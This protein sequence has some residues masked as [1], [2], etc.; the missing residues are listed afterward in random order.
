MIQNILFFLH[1]YPGCGGIETVTTKLAN[2]LV[3]KGKKICIYSLERN[4]SEE[5]LSEL[6]DRVM[7]VASKNTSSESDDNCEQLVHLMDEKKIEL[8]IFQDSY[9]P[10]ENLLLKAKKQHD[11]KIWVVE[12]NTPDS[13]ILA[14]TNSKPTKAFY[15]LKRALFYPLYIK[16]ISSQTRNRTRNL[17]NSFDKYILL[18][19]NFIPVW[20]EVTG[21]KSH[22]RLTYINN[23]LTITRPDSFQF[24]KEKICLFCGRLVSQKGLDMLMRIWEKV[25]GRSKDWNLIIV[26]DG[27]EKGK[28]EQ[29]IEERKLKNVYLEGFRKNT[30][31]YYFKSSILCMASIYEGWLLSLVEAMAYGCVPFTFNSYAAAEDIIQNGENGY[32][33]APFAEDEYVEKLVGLMKSGDELKVMSRNAFESSSKFSVEKIGQK[34]LEII[35]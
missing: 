10:V 2:F 29:F 15:K 24:E 30:S 22:D 13:R 35:R 3:E 21:I 8:V 23:P 16:K 25:E 20:E 18:S 31:E 19:K 33:I 27:P 28:I 26:G 1:N 11:C 14:F 4:H 9:N 34:W 32:L 7:F 12:H 17:Y 6:D 5:L